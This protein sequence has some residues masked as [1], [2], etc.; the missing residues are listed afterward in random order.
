MKGNDLWL[1][2]NSTS[3]PELTQIIFSQ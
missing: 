3:T 2:W 1:V